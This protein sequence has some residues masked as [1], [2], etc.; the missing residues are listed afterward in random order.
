MNEVAHEEPWA[1]E[2]PVRQATSTDA[3]PA[4]AEPV[5]QIEEDCVDSADEP[6]PRPPDG[7]ES[8][9]S[10]HHHE[11]DLSV[12]Y[13]IP[14]T[15]NPAITNP[16]GMPQGAP[17]SGRDG[18]VLV[19]TRRST[20]SANGAEHIP[21]FMRPKQAPEPSIL[22]SRSPAQDNRAVSAS[23]PT[24]RLTLCETNELELE[25]RGVIEKEE[26][27][28]RTHLEHRRAAVAADIERTA[29][30]RAEYLASEEFK[31]LKE[32]GQR[33]KR[34]VQDQEESKKRAEE[35]SITFR[36][37]VS[38]AAAARPSR[39]VSAFVKDSEEWIKRRASE[40]RAVSA[41]RDAEREQA[42]TM[43]KRS[44]AIVKKLELEHKHVGIV[45]GW[46]KRMEEHKQRM[47]Q[48]D[49]RY[50]PTFKPSINH[51][52]SSPA[53]VPANDAPA[54]VTR[55][56]EKAL[57]QRK[58]R[59]EKL[60]AIRKA[61]EP[62][63]V[64]R[65]E[66]EIREHFERMTQKAKEAQRQFKHKRDKIVKEEQALEHNNFKPLV[67]KRSIAL[68]EKFRSGKLALVTAQTKREGSEGPAG[69][70]QDAS[71]PAESPSPN[72]PS[73]SLTTTFATKSL[74]LPANIPISLLLNTKCGEHRFAKDTSPVHET[75][76][77]TAPAR[78][79]EFQLRYERMLQQKK[80]KV[81]EWQKTKDEL[82]KKECTFAPQISATSKKIVE[83]AVE[84]GHR[85]NYRDPTTSQSI[86]E[87]SLEGPQHQTRSVSQ[88]ATGPAVPPIQA[89]VPPP[90]DNLA[91]RLQDMENMI[92]H[93]KQLEEQSRM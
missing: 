51:P 78:S 50:T 1:D 56:Y 73:G 39:S 18:A 29:A 93:W 87:G 2:Q 77:K 28:D 69:S 85:P 88:G 19:A 68:A 92:N 86:R 75:H 12:R 7:D 91:A 14:D 67:N 21:H 52:T 37:A 25:K 47:E 82:E 63:V 65:N 26:Q 11:A 42:F 79:L 46:E 40:Q 60:E 76:V 44:L 38:A 57:E 8:T 71:P 6:F 16:D 81:D 70:D 9:T 32:A 90:D 84:E 72:R 20:P 66:T 80:Q 22:R 27:K 49:K 10:L 74:Q 89:S 64:K 13:S 58:R 48:L 35:D 36:P 30:R 24:R 33:K 15:P 54:P 53:S 31:K 3:R 5:P 59:E 45:E 34:T 43:T 55:L 17:T 23:R 83:K 62:P 61:T 4:H 41:T